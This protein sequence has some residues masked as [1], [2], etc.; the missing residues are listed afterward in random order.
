MAC[1][2]H[3]YSKE[4]PDTLYIGQTRQ[5]PEPRYERDDSD[6]KI[7]GSMF[8]ARP[9]DHFAGLYDSHENPMFLE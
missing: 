3:I 7:S 1:I 5:D 8:Q 6:V 4:D 2:Y 9:M